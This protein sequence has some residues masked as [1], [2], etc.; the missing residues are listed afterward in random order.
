MQ[1][2]AI[3]QYTVNAEGKK[4]VNPFKIRLVNEVKPDPTTLP[5][6]Y[7]YEVSAY[8]DAKS[9]HPLIHFNVVQAPD[10][11]MWSRVSREIFNDLSKYDIFANEGKPTLMVV[12]ADQEEPEE[13][14]DDSNWATGELD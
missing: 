8:Y 1:A 6:R 7:V 9:V 3:E 2:T 14:V 10:R 11:M 5:A 12:E 4:E 13:E